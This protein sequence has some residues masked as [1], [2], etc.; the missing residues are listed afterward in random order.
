MR[1]P[2]VEEKMEKEEK[3]AAAVQEVAEKEVVLPDED[4]Q[5]VTTQEV[6]TQEV[7]QPRAYVQE[8]VPPN[9]KAESAPSQLVD[10]HPRT[11][12]QLHH[13]VAQEEHLQ[14]P[15]PQLLP[16]KENIKFGDQLPAPTPESRELTLQQKVD[17]APKPT[18]FSHKFFKGKTSKPEK[19][20][21]SEEVHVPKFSL[22]SLT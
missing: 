19:A 3:V 17:A 10:P 16:D 5:E 12:Q 2:E 22:E 21:L 1:G 13:L 20:E 18:L 9:A 6:A 14:Q 15:S 7:A 11:L 4:V 8:V